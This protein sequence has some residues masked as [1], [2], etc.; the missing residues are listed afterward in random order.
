MTNR[1]LTCCWLTASFGFLH[2]ER[3]LINENNEVQDLRQ[4]NRL[5]SNLRIITRS[6]SINRVLIRKPSNLF[7]FFKAV[8]ERNCLH[9]LS[10]TS[11]TWLPANSEPFWRRRWRFV[12]AGKRTDRRHFEGHFSKNDSVSLWKSSLI[13]SFSTAAQK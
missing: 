5:G 9:K 1:F 3:R 4:H 10:K 8:T 12:L 13:C 11:F 7:D 6:K 2:R